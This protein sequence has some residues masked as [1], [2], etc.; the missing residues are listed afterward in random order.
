M[1]IKSLILIGGGLLL[2]AVIGHGFWLAWRNKQSGL[3]VKLDTRIPQEDLDTIDLLRGELPNGGARVRPRATEDPPLT[4]PAREGSA[5]SSLRGQ[6]VELGFPE[7]GGST[8][9]TAAGDRI[10]TA[11]GSAQRSPAPQVGAGARPRPQQPAAKARPAAAAQE[12]SADPELPDEVVIINVL[13][14]G[15][16]QFAGDALMDLFLRH[17]LKFGDMN[18]FHRLDASSR[19]PLFSLASAVEPGTFDLAAMDSFRT[20]GVSL[21]MRLPCAGDPLSC[22]NDMLL[23]ARDIATT[24]SGDMK[25]E[26]FS[27]MTAQSIEHCRSRIT[28][29]TRKSLSHRD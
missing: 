6:Q 28:D 25:D 16:D 1:D 19:Q 22:F 12:R 7:A 14:R 18:I 27:V 10:L 17:N 3:K 5:A 15:G 24:L 8:L 2:A 29:Y 13:A 4:P 23:V 26:Q 21:F 20:K 9:T 11:R